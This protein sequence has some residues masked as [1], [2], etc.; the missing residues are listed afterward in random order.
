MV[1]TGD[2]AAFVSMGIPFWLLPPCKKSL[3]L[4]SFFPHIGLADPDTMA[5]YPPTAGIP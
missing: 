1:Q 5:W 3:D 2:G 4:T